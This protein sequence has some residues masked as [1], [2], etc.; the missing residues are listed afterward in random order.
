M[1]IRGFSLR[2]IALSICGALG[3]AEDTLEEHLDWWFS[4]QGLGRSETAALSGWLMAE[5]P[6]IGGSLD[7]DMFA[8]VIKFA[9]AESL[10][11]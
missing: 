2:E 7:G 3:L 9:V 1:G 8:Q 10:L 5:D 6:T 4:G 11:S